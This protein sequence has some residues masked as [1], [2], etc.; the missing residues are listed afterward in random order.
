MCGT[1]NYPDSLNNP[2]CRP[3]C[4]CNA[5]CPFDRACIGWKCADPCLGSCGENAHC[6]VVHHTPVCS[7]PL[8]LNGDPY[9]GCFQAADE[10]DPCSL[11]QC[12]ANARCV[13]QNGV[14]TCQCAPEYYGNPYVA[15]HLECLQNTDCGLNQACSNH[16]CINPCEGACGKDASCDVINH[17]PVC[18]CDADSTGNPFQYCTRFPYGPPAPKPSTCDPSPCGAN[19]RC[20][21]SD[22]GYA[23]CSC[24]PGFRGI[25]P[26]CSPECVVSSDCLQIQTCVNMKCVN[27]CN[28][29]CGHGALCSVINHN[30]ICTC[31]P[32]QL[33]DP[34]F[35]CYTDDGREEPEPPSS[36]SPSPCGPHSV[37]QV[38]MGRPVCSCQSNFIGMPPNCRPE[39][40]IS[41]EC[42]TDMACV[43]FK[44]VHP[45]PS[46]CGPNSECTIV[47]HTPYCSCKPGFEG[48]A[49]IGCTPKPA[50]PPVPINPCDT[51]NCGNNAFCTVHDGVPRCNCIPPYIGDPYS[52][53]RPEC[54][55]N[56]D[57]VSDLA[58]IN[59]HCRNPCQGVC[60]VNAVCEVINHVPSCSCQ[61]GFTGEPFQSCTPDRHSMY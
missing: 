58:C 53:C 24:L 10:P 38:K 47:N 20:T 18:Y 40:L 3:E 54:M 29:V 50:P 48:D 37:C 5:D 59:Q 56:S 39:C 15:C 21:L 51:L 33:G 8:G 52:G 46:S 4:L 32:G 7:C 6:R 31:P 43:A 60:G 1:C 57:C 34:F 23:T 36:C 61:P 27:P 35:K 13:E 26:L 22:Q 16:K 30:P 2:F 14:T 25:P 44:C 9:R 41:Q 42:P 49:F 55:M 11:A 17:S 28:S 12:G 19:S 45:C